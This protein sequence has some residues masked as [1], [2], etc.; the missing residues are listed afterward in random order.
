VRL[1]FWGHISD[2]REMLAREMCPLTSVW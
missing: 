2:P 1:L